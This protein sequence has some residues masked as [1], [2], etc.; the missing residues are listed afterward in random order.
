MQ[1]T[2]Q[3][4]KRLQAA[5]LIP[6]MAPIDC[7]LLRGKY[8]RWPTMLSRAISCSS[9]QRRRVRRCRLNMLKAGAAWAMRRSSSCEDMLSAGA[10]W[11][12]RRSSSCGGLSCG[13]SRWLVNRVLNAASHSRIIYNSYI[14]FSTSIFLCPFEPSVAFGIQQSH[15]AGCRFVRASKREI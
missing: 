5:W 6:S 10:I 12:I 11:E 1:A 4:S 13:R 9:I 3:T 8:D 15:R 14:N 7:H 2:K